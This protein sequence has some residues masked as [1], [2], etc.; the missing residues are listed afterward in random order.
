MNGNSFGRLWILTL[1]LSAIGGILL[2][3]GAIA[4][5]GPNPDTWNQLQQYSQ[6]GRKQKSRQSQ[7][8]SV[9]QLS[10]VQPTDWAFEALQSLVERFGCIA[11]YPDG[12]FKGNRSLSRYEFA[13]GVY[14]CVDRIEEL[15]EAGTRDRVT[16]AEL[17]A[18][19]RL[20]NE[21]AAELALLRG[22]MRGIDVRLDEIDDNQFSVTT[23]LRGE[24]IFALTDAFGED[25]GSD[26]TV[27]QNRVRLDFN[28]SFT[29]RDLLLTR[30]ES[31]DAEP[32]NG[33]VIGQGTQT[34]NITD[35]TD[36]S[37][38]L[39]RLLYQFPVGDRL[40]FT[41]AAKGAT[42]DDFVPTLNPYLD[43][44]DGGNGS[45]SAFGQ[46]NPIYR[47]GG[48]T[49][50]GINYQF[51]DRSFASIFGPTSLSVGYL[52]AGAGDATAG[53]GLF[54]GDF[55]VLA[56][57][58]VTPADTVQFALTY[59]YTYSTPGNFGFDNGEQNGPVFD[60]TTGEVR[61]DAFNGY[62]G[63]GIANSL[64]GL[65]EGL[66]P[67][68]I[69]APVSS[70]SYGVQ[71]AWQI[72]PRVI[73]GAWGGYTAARAIGV[74]DGQI[75]NYALTLGLP[76]LFREGSLG[77]IV[78]GRE[79]Y[80]AH[81]DGESGRGLPNDGSWHFEAFYRYQLTDYLSITPG[82][83]WITNPNQSDRN[84]DLAIGTVRTTFAF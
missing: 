36:N 1:T 35:D 66:N 13:A 77:G 45:L 46:R 20:Q 55:S 60:R 29:G 69:A 34:F 74:G 78:V 48:G 50:I 79:P 24:A 4:T 17:L 18:L 80:L 68:G 21:F 8:T 2:P 83:I 3:L 73:L 75:W 67:A 52:A 26:Q 53:T 62:A 64:Y 49:G 14:A 39:A 16:Q 59:N 22:D 5:P 44:Y 61:I 82:I 72:S 56:Q 40:N 38:R 32:F 57:L 10:D 7:V 15:I 43:D 27:W 12:T 11:G 6:E 30:L 51:G 9:S 65:T 25:T 81:L 71:L 70:N 84:D 63:T 58:T 23:K 31:G 19:K 33:G 54:N 42:W 28:T 76:D 37:V 41:L 47:L